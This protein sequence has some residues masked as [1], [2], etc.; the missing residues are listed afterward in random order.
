MQQ[1]QDRLRQEY[2]DRQQRGQETAP[3]P[4]EQSQDHQPIATEAD[5]ALDHI[6]LCAI[7]I[8]HLCNE[9]RPIQARETLKLLMR[10]QMEDRRIRTEQ[11]RKASQQAGDQLA[12]LKTMLKGKQRGSSETAV[13]PETKPI[14]TAVDFEEQDPRRETDKSRAIKQVARQ[15]MLNL[16][17]DLDAG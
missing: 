6:R 4:E 16:L 11:L 9:W 8:H 10:N 13:Q 15:R 1:E 12:S 7:N 2:E 5:R 17:V 14:A 3:I